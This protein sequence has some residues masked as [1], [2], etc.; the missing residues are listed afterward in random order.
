MVC[1]MK[2]HQGRF[3]KKHFLAF[4]VHF[5]V[6]FSCFAGKNVELHTTVIPVIFSVSV[7]PGIRYSRYRYFSV[8]IIGVL[9]KFPPLWFG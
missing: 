5:L 2:S 3:Q 8:G 4:Y 1:R 9:A 7:F 6:F